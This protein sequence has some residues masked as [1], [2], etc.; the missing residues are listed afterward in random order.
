MKKY[1]T[2]KD[3]LKK[4]MASL[5]NKILIL[6]KEKHEKEVEL[7]KYIK[8]HRSLKFDML[9]TDDVE[10]LNKIYRFFDAKYPIKWEGGMRCDDR[11]MKLH[12]WIDDDPNFLIIH[13]SSTSKNICFSGS[14][15]WIGK[16]PTLSDKV[17]LLK[18]IKQK[19]LKIIK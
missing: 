7:E 5:N 11:G 8:C 15:S 9:E 13:L 18:I 17:E 6:E 1:E 16:A 14:T 19:V 10:K 2:R 12:F 3:K 4:Q